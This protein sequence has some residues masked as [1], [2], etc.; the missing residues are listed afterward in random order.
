MIKLLYGLT[1][2]FMNYANR[3]YYENSSVK[4]VSYVFEKPNTIFEW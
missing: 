2:A 4:N 3:K 1:S